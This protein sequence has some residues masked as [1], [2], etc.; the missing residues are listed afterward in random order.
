MVI[1]VNII[2]RES[3]EE[4]YSRISKMIDENFDLRYIGSKKIDNITEYVA[5]M[6]DVVC[7]YFV[8]TKVHNMVCDYNYYL[9]DYVCTD[10]EYQGRGVATKMMEFA[11][12]KAK[13][14]KGKYIQLTSS[15]K[16]V[17]AHHIY[18][19]LG[20]EKYDT[21]VFRRELV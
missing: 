19:K 12:E 4:D 9:I 11:I 17:I 2:I 6:D 16:R 20:Y 7:G 3:R 13:E 15:D 5:V 1:I 8:F 10:V 18:E 21:N 14:L